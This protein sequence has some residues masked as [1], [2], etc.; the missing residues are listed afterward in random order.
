MSQNVYVIQQEAGDDGLYHWK[1]FLADPGSSTTG[2][3]YDVVWS[4]DKDEGS[5]RRGPKPYSE[6]MS[7]GFMGSHAI[8][9]IAS[10]NVQQFHDVV[11]ATPTPEYSV[12]DKDKNCQTWLR[13]VVS[14]LVNAGLLESSALTKVD[15][16]PKEED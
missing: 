4:A 6:A 3:W 1:L 8:G 12:A 11:V 5:K 15:N 2:V 7:R 13:E 9:S 14:G 16:V 10:A